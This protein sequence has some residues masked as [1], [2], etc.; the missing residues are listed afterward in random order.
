MARE[1]LTEPERQRNHH[2]ERELHESSNK[3]R[4]RYLSIWLSFTG[5]A[6]GLGLAILSYLELI[7]L[8][9]TVGPYQLNHWAAWLG[10][11][12]VTIYVPLFIVLKKRYLK[13]YQK[14]IK[15]HEIGFIT[16]FV[17]VSLHIGWQIRRVFPPE[18]GTGVALYLCL[19]GLVVT[20]IMQRNRILASRANTL[21]FVHLSLVV[22]FFLII[23]FHI[24]R[25]LLFLG[26]IPV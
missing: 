5:V 2:P 22:S 26:Q 8:D 6:V 19:F 15:V 25:A 9:Y 18:I 12:F 17:V 16:A 24:I 20:G 10:F 13:I 23:V 7:P 4:S 3:H 11:G 21:R 14:L 1:T